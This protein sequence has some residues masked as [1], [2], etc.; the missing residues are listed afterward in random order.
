MRLQ[1]AIKKGMKKEVIYEVECIV[2][3]CLEDQD[4]KIEEV[5]ELAKDILALIDSGVK[6]GVD[7]KT[8]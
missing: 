6:G 7:E 5:R 1:E 3:R 8:I 2:K 4:S